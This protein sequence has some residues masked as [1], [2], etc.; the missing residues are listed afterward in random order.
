MPYPL[1]WV[2]TLEIVTHVDPKEEISTYL[3]W[4]CPRFD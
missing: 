2:S 3:F 1:P 4:E